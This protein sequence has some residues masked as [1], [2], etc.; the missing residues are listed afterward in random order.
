MP[1]IDPRSLLFNLQFK[2][3]ISEDEIQKILGKWHYTSIR[4][5]VADVKRGKVP[6]AAEDAAAIQRSLAE[7]KDLTTRIKKVEGEIPIWVKFQAE[8]YPR[9]EIN[10]Y[11]W[12]LTPPEFRA[13][14]QVINVRDI[15]LEVDLEAGLIK[16][17]LSAGGTTNT[18]VIDAKQHRIMHQ[19]ADF[20]E[21]YRQ[22]KVFCPHLSAVFRRLRERNPELD[23][24]I[25]QSICT[26]P[27]RWVFEEGH[28]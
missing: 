23:R 24:E 20:N 3:K 25:L 19:C 12:K 9:D 7:Q 13:K 1:I 14:T 15:Q 4:Q 27:E 22:M 6:G 17:S 28:G 2:F 8:M 10:D 5:F 18:M 11:Y 26:E 16:A 21:H